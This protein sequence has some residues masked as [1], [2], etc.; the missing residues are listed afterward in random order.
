MKKKILHVMVAL[1]LSGILFFIP[2]TS[3]FAASNQSKMG[4]SYYGLNR[5]SS[6]DL[7]GIKKCESEMLKFLQDVITC[8][9]NQI[10]I[11]QTVDYEY[12]YKIYNVDSFNEN[13]ESD[14]K[15]ADYSYVLDWCINGIEYEITYSLGHAPRED[16]S[17]SEEEYREL[18]ENV[19]K[20][21][22]SS[23]GKIDDSSISDRNAID[24]YDKSGYDDVIICAGMDGC[25]WPVI[26][27][28]S[29]GE[30]ETIAPIYDGSAYQV[31][32]EWEAEN[33]KISGDEI[34][35]YDEIHEL[36]DQL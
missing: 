25:G 8:E 26:I 14:L 29:A 15:S 17:Y 19:G 28:I 20:W 33:C 9:G 3:S 31:F 10:Q 36:S 2:C 5:V 35:D 27:G 16:V 13:V 21:V 11:P 12:L 6:E 22:V 34:Y 7:Q 4:S 32:S 23:I 18:S 24:R 30:A 1:S